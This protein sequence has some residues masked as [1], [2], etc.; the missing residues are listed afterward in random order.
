MFDG[1]WSLNSAV[2]SKN[3]LLS[4]LSLCRFNIWTSCILA[5][6]WEVILSNKSF[7]DSIVQSECNISSIAIV[8]LFITWNHI[9]SW[10]LV[11]LCSFS[12]NTH[13]VFY[14][15]HYSHHMS[16][17]T[18]SSFSSR[19]NAI[20]SGLIKSH[21]ICLRNF[22][23]RLSVARLDVRRIRH[24]HIEL[25]SSFIHSLVFKLEI[26]SLS[27]V[28]ILRVMDKELIMINN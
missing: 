10:E 5:S 1:I 7:T 15:W 25:E 12:L 16:W 14:C 27:K 20:L 21:I 17:C 6:P 13:S 24:S 2:T 9:L 3:C 28:M 4:I 22:F 19:L 18:V 26:C 23:C 11:G 8:I